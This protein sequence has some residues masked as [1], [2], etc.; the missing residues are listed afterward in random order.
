MISNE[1]QKE[2]THDAAFLDHHIVTIR[3]IRP[4]EKLLHRDKF[5]SLSIT[6]HAAL[7]L[8]QIH[9]HSLPRKTHFIALA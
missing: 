1:S 7:L 4:F 9:D 8:P 5:S 3:T 2:W 6:H